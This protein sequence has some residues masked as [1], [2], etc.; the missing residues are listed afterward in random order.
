MRSKRCGNR[1][2]A[3]EPATRAAKR[4]ARPAT[5]LAAAIKRAPRLAAPKQARVRLDEWLGE[6][7][8]TAPGKALKQLL[9]GPKQG[10]LG[11]LIVSIA[12]ASSYLWD[13]IRADP[14]RF[15]AMLEANP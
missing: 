4:I 7:A 12:E 13:L 1:N 8:R 11:D 6:V 10:K 15:A 14:A 3:T 2:V 5:G 9:A